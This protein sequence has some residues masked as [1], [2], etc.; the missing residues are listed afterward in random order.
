MQKKVIVIGSG[1]SGLSSASY[2]AK[3]GFDVTVYEKNE[4]IGG[5]ASVLKENGYTFDMGPSWYWMPEVFER[6]FNDFGNSVKDY[7]SLE[8]LDPS[9]RV[10]FKKD[11]HIDISSEL[12]KVKDLFETLEHG[13]SK[14]L[15]LFIA[16]AKKKYDISFKEFISLP[17]HSIKELIKI[18]N[19]SHLKQK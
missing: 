8:K 2:L 16:D 7:Y 5:R 14:K 3:H 17:G 6:F 9:Y 13:S 1:F 15:D 18:K 12:N 4:S 19:L 11:D 10:F